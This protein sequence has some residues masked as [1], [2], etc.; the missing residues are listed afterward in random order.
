M[1]KR[2]FAIFDWERRHPCLHE[3]DSVQKNSTKIQLDF[4]SDVLRRFA[5]L[6]GRDACAPSPNASF[7][8]GI[9]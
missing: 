6:S 4:T 3:R 1:L 9:S 8:R 7:Y 2:K 5:P